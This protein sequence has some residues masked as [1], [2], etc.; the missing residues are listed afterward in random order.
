M[1]IEILMP[2]KKKTKAKPKR[3]KTINLYEMYEE[4][5]DY[6][7][8]KVNT[9][10]EVHKQ[11][12]YDV[13]VILHDISPDGVQLRCNRKTAYT[14]HPTGKFITDKTAPEVVLNFTLPIDNKEKEVIVQ[15]KIYYFTI[16]ATDVVAFGAKFKNFKKFTQ[17]H[18]DNY[19]MKSVIPVE[20]KVL[21]ILHTPRTGDDIHKHVDDENINLHD[22]LDILRRKKAIISYEDDK[23]RKFVKLESAIESIFKRLDKIEKRLD[24]TGQ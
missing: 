21:D 4:K 5:R 14:I 19:I 23:T 10:A 17:R 24:K 9:L 15:S 8:I 13:N 6:P 2:Q 11:D 12:E 20:E 7:R 16:I 1:D 3:K 22:T 18:V